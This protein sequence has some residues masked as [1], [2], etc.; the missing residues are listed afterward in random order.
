MNR[1][2]CVL[3]GGLAL[4]SYA[5]A[6]PV[7]PET[8][9]GKAATYLFHKGR[10]Q[11]DGEEQMYSMVIGTNFGEI[12]AMLSYTPAGNGKPEAR[13]LVV[14]VPNSEKKLL[15]I[16]T[17]LDDDIDFIADPQTDDAS[18]F[19]DLSIAQKRAV[20][21]NY[22]N[23]LRGFEEGYEVLPALNI[24]VREYILENGT[25][26]GDRYCLPFYTP[27]KSVEFCYSTGQLSS[28]RD[29][30]IY[31]HFLELPPEYPSISEAEYY[32]YDANG[33]LDKEIIHTDLGKVDVT[34]R[35]RM[36]KETRAS[37]DKGLREQIKLVEEIVERE[38][39]LSSAL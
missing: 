7:F 15:Y 18:L 27:G 33:T 19:G 6:D 5:H 39:T 31:I 21:R 10:Q 34:L 4:S 16:D 24:V 11:F 14:E 17:E 30:E 8:T 35:Q 23:F 22:R 25:K 29:D 26:Q 13:G 32:D 2:L 28:S 37:R 20:R 36:T 1:S 9:S 38:Y 12:P 3:V